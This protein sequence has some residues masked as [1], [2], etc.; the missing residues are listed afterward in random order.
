MKMKNNI[1]NYFA[2]VVVAFL[3][4][5]TTEASTKPIDTSLVTTQQLQKN[6]EKWFCKEF[7]RSYMPIYKG[8]TYFITQVGIFK[9]VGP[10]QV[11][12]KDKWLQ[13]MA[14]GQFTEYVMSAKEGYKALKIQYNGKNIGAI[15]CHIKQDEEHT[16]HIA[17]FFI[18]P[19]YQSKG[20]A[21]YVIDKLLP[22]SNPLTKQ[23]EVLVRHQDGPALWLFYNKLSFSLG[24]VELVKKY[25]RD[26]KYFVG[27][28]K[29]F[30][31]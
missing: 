13:G 5:V 11:Q 16:I 20:I 25:E 23:Y 14:K 9:L 6:D 28:Y 21:S 3:L 15:L 26:P 29:A 27:L 17:D 1:R 22:A 18:M 4:H 2:L 12:E 7:G 24:D 19:E 8:Q 10:N 31:K 30:P